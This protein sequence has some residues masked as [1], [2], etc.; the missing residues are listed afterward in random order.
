MAGG[1]KGKKNEQNLSNL[2]NCFRKYIENFIN[3][4]NKNKQ[5]MTWNPGGGESID[6]YFYKIFK[7][8]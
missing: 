1:E 8:L 7:F 4:E 6:S 3:N 2:L 5:M